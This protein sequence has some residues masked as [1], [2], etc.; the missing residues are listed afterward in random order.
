MHIDFRTVETMEEL[1]TLGWY[2]SPHGLRNVEYWCPDLIEFRP[3]EALVINSLRSA[4][5]SCS[6]GICPAEGLF[7]GGI[8]TRYRDAAGR[9]VNAFSQAFG[10]FEAEV[11]VPSGT[12]M[13]SA[14]WLQSEGTGRVG[15]RG[16]DG[17]E[18]DIY[19]SAFREQP[20]LSGNAIHYDAYEYPAY[21]SYGAV[22]DT[23]INLYEGFH[24]Y[25]LLWTP[26]EYVFFVDGEPVWA[27]NFG[28]V[29]RVAE[30]LRLTVEIRTG[31]TGPYG[32]HIGQ[33]DNAHG[34]GNEFRIRSV[35][36]YQNQRYKPAIK[37]P[38]DFSRASTL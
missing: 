7:T 27:T 37:T 3:G 33:F 5:H 4:G 16:M 11:Q 24:R 2:T 9:W 36:V 13:W 17:S 10:Y 31:G 28:G 18:I 21:R 34:E 29:S 15:D 30:F 14:F 35:K 38:A 26:T 23:G 1:N 25:G 22:S 32:Q 12:G 20:S 8:E 19:E 6:Q